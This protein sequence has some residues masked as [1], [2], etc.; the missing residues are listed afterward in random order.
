MFFA[1]HGGAAL[2]LGSS[3][4]WK[5]MSVG[6]VGTSDG[7]QDLNEHF[8]MEWEYQR[9]ENGNLACTGEIDLAACN[10]EF[11]LALGFG[12]MWSE[13][14]QQVRSSLLEDYDDLRRQYVAALE[15]LANHADQTG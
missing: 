12:G 14:G 1:E 5:K 11:V 15:E 8:Q 2:A 9:A 3:A 13:A 7:W 4:P 10:G 6:F